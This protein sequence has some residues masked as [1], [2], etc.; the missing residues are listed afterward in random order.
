MPTSP[1]RTVRYDAIDVLRGVAL[2]W[3]VVYH[4][5]FD[6]NNFGLVRLDFYRDPAWTLQR[7]A[8]LSLFLFCAGL[9]Q[10]TAGQQGQPWARFWHRWWQIVGCAVLVSAGSWWMFPGS[11]IY[12]GVLHGLALML[13][14]A[15]L[16]AGWG[17]W[18]L[19]PAL[20][21][22]IA[23]PLAAPWL[24]GSPWQE[25]LNAPALNWLGLV[26]RKPVT[27]D[28]VPLLPWIGV[29]W[30]GVVAGTVWQRAARPSATWQAD[31]PWSLLAW[32]GRHSLA[33]YMLHQPLLIGALSLLTS[34][35]P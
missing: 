27:E 14:L 26:S 11:F 8:I 31:G 4:F 7:T 10:A 16:T 20:L 3:M 9:G 6:L 33:V 25:W 12:F 35:A 22:L 19:L 21:A 23:P 15:R 28:F 1:S 5:C 2:V 17:A 24:A 32:L 29:V 34:R 30:L 13:I 18:L